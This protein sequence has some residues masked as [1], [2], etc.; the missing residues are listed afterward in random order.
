MKPMTMRERM[1]AVV[2]GREHDRVPFVQYSGIAA[3]NEEV[4]AVIGRE[5]MGLLQWCGVHGFAHPNCRWEQKDIVSDGKQGKIRTL[6]TPEGS[7]T[8]ESVNAAIGAA[9]RKHFVCE[10]KDYRILLS[11]FRDITVRKITEGWQKAYAQ[12]G[13]DGIPHTSI[14]RSPYQQLWVE[15]VS[16]EDLSLH[17]VDVPELMEEVFAVMFDVQRRLLRVVQEAARELPIPYVNYAD[18][19]TAPTIGL[20]NFKK[21]C[22]PLYNEL[23]DLLAET[24]K[25]I[26]VAVHM[27]GDLKPLW[28]AIGESKVRLLDSLSPPPDN[29]TSIA[30][31]V[32]VWPEMRLCLNFPSS[33]HLAEPDGIYRAAMEIL[34]QGGRTG[35]LQIQ[36]SENVPPGSW[37]KSYPQIVRAIRDFGASGA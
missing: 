27:D 24:G 1:L 3:P 32:R 5:N 15:W 13:D 33:I 14:G 20:T 17:M 12:L 21:Y 11:Y 18:N 30:D 7:L 22:V 35:R 10:P 31:A 19:I 16:L 26:P 6:H 8:E 34:E 36:I 2:Q 4:W 23:A 37:R 9:R 29:D 28:G 25:D